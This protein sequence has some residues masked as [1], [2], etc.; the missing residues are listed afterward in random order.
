M[1]SKIMNPIKTYLGRCG[2]SFGA[3]ALLVP[4]MAFGLTSCDDADDFE[5]ES[6]EVEVGEDDDLEV[7]E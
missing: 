3:L 4:F 7:T 1:K 6:E 2:A 5:D